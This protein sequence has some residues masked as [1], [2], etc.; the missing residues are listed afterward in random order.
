M[1]EP[2]SNLDP[3]GERALARALGMAK[4][5]QITVI[6]ITQRPSL[7][8]SV[9]KIMILTK[10]TVQALGERND[11]IPLLTARKELAAQKAETN[12]G[13]ANYQAEDLDDLNR[14]DE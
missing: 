13:E 11:I 1:D 5:K 12:G 7:L 9:D 6:A 8:R 4:D 2:N 10:G 3:P 14:D